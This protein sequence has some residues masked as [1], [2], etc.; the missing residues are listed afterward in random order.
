MVLSTIAAI[1][2]L[3]GLLGTVTGMISAF[4]TIALEG[5]GDPQELAGGISQALLTTAGGLTIA[6]PCLIGF[7]AFDSQVNGKVNQI[8]IASAEVVNAL[9]SSQGK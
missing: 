9:V 5:T 7:N 8:E 3:F 4:T 1:S 6:I 2:P